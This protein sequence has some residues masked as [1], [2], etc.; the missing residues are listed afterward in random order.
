[1]VTEKAT[2]FYDEMKIPNKCTFSNRWLESNKK[3]YIYLEEIW[4]VHILLRT[5]EYLIFQ[6]LPG[7]VSARLKKFYYILKLKM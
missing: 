1:M 5:M 6:Q 7:T 2:Y 4:A 3:I